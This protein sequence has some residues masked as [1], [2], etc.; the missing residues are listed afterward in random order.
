MERR[1][2]KQQERDT[3]EGKVNNFKELKKKREG[4]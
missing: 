4:G 2:R 3:N 1:Q